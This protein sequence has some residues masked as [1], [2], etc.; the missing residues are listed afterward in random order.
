MR[1]RRKICCVAVV[2]CALGLLGSAGLAGAEGTEPVAGAWKGKT[3]QG[4]F[5]Y[6]RVASDHTVTNIRFTYRESICG[7]QSP[8]DPTTK[9]SIDEAGQ[10]GGAIYSARLEFEG[11]F[12]TAKRVKGKLI[13][14]ETTGLPGCLRQVVEFSAQPR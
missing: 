1:T 10:F 2:I 3:K 13:A 14:L 12:V 6:F 7:K 5:V 9:L 8:H 4:F 11:T